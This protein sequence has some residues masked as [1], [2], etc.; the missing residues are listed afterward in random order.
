MMKQ[1]IIVIFSVA[2]LA[3]C[4]KDEGFVSAEEQLAIDIVK[5]DKYLEE[6]NIIAEIHETGVRYVIDVEGTGENPGAN[7]TVRVNY[8]GRL[9]SNGEVFDSN[10]DIE[11]PLS[12]VIA[13]WQIGIPLFKEG[14]SGTL[15]IPSGW[16]YGISGS[17][18]NIGA[19]AILIFDIDLLEVN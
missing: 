3:G 7:S 18:S 11:F 10:D 19:N 1:V 2:L 16:A 8:E 13:G 5:I 4:S 15:Y 12:G 17:G 14:G 9:M 6:N